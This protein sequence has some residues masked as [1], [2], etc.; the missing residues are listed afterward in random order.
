MRTYSYTR[1]IVRATALVACLVALGVA[2]ILP[3]T[4]ARAAPAR[5]DTTP[6]QRSSLQLVSSFGGSV[7]AVAAEAGRAYIG[8]GNALVV[9]DAASVGRPV[10]LGRLRLPELVEG[11]AVAGGVAYVALGRGGLVL[12]L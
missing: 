6:A 2:L 7:R 1:R 4:L 3:A 8:E 10:P 5:D 11:V 12:Q 9:L